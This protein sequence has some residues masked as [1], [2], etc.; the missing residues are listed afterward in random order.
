MSASIYSKPALFNAKLT[1]D[2]VLFA[3]FLLFYD[4]VFP[5]DSILLNPFWYVSSS[6]DLRLFC[7]LK[8]V[9]E[10]N[11]RMDCLLRVELVSLPPNWVYPFFFFISFFIFFRRRSMP[12]LKTEELPIMERCF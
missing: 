4:P 7:T 6:A 11:D 9:T 3:L 1:I 10:R 2:V 8:L 12:S 5:A